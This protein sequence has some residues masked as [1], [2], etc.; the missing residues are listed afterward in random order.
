MVIRYDK[1]FIQ[2]F[3]ETDE[4][5]LTIT[6]CPITTRCFPYRRTDG[7]LSM[8]AKLP[9]ELFLRQLY[10]QQMLSQ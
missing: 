5:Y 1:A 2:D 7:G 4:G 9:D 10:F 3:K 6:A 8:E